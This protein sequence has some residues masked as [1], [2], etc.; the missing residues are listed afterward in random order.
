[1]RKSDA[2]QVITD[3]I[4]T[5]LEAGTVP[6]HKPWNADV[7]MPRN[8][9]SGKE[10]R[11]INVF[12]LGTQHYVS[13]YWLTFN[14]C[15]DRGGSVRKGEKS[16]PVVFWKVSEYTATDEETGEVETRKGFLLRYYNVF[17]VEQCEGVEYP[18]PATV[19]ND[20]LPLEICE[21]IVVNMPNAPEIRHGV[22]GMRKWRKIVDLK[23]RTRNGWMRMPPDRRA[24]PLATPSKGSGIPRV[25]L[26]CDNSCPRG[27]RFPHGVT[28]DRAG[29]PSTYCQG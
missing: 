17:N 21:Q 16:T 8:L 22:S 23:I 28:A 10:Y 3:R 29:P 24:S 27:Q 25:C 11:D 13:P 20:L 1:M 7:G 6:W 5:L 9:A 18:Q 4:V 14:Q 15:K 12:M 26:S 19:T 2:Y